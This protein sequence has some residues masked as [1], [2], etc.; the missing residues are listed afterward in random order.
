MYERPSM[1]ETPK[2]IMHKHEES[3]RDYVKRFCNVRNT[4]PYIQDIKIINDFH[5]GVSDIKTV[6]QITMKKPKP[7]V[8]LL[9]VANI[10]I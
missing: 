7:M 9:A 6:N 5:D 3:V 4:I 8:D 10:Y 2:T 1:A